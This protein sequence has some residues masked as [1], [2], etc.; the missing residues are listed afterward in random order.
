MTKK[1][2]IKRLEIPRTLLH[3][4]LA[5]SISL[6]YY[7]FLS[8]TVIILTL[9]LIMLIFLFFEINKRLATGVGIKYVTTLKHFIR[10]SELGKKWIGALTALIGYLLAIL[11]FPQRIAVVSILFLGIGDPFARYIRIFRNKRSH[12]GK[13]ALGTLG[14]FVIC[15]LISYFIGKYSLET[16]VVVACG[17]AFTESFIDIRVTEAFNIDDNILVPIIGGLILYLLTL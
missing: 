7:F 9:S 4:G 3:V 10:I 12:F 8:K 5:L 17:T 13:L 16:S 6:S 11:F 14:M 15:F 1:E 2:L